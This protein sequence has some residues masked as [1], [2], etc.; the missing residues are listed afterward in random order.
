MYMYT[1]L[2]NKSYEDNVPFLQYY[3]FCLVCRNILY[4]YNSKQED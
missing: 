3:C 2:F 1:L 4:L